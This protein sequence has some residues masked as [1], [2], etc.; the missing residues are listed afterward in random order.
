MANG[1][2]KVWK[3]SRFD[4]A[5]MGQEWVFSPRRLKPERFEQLNEGQVWL[6]GE[7]PRRPEAAIFARI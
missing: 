4:F 1:T 5:P 2:I 7:R 3:R 6:H